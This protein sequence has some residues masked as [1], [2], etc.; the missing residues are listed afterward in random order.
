MLGRVVPATAAMI[1]LI[2][3]VLFRWRT[4]CQWTL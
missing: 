3:T 4:K 1:P 2:M